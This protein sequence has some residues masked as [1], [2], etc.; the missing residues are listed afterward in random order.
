MANSVLPH[1]L[2]TAAQEGDETAKA[3]VYAELRPFLARVASEFADTPDAREELGQ[4]AALSLFTHL[5]GYVVGS[6][7]A[8]K[9][10]LLPRVRQDVRNAHFESRFLGTIDGEAASRYSRAYGEAHG[11][12]REARNRGEYVSDAEIHEDVKTRLQNIGHGLDWDDD[13]VRAADD[14]FNGGGV[15]YLSS[16]TD[17]GSDDSY[18]YDGLESLPDP[19]MDAAFLLS[20]GVVGKE[21]E[22]AVRAMKREMAT[23][24]MSHL[25]ENHR[26]TIAVS[27]GVDQA[28]GQFIAG[29]LDVRGMTVREGQ[30]EE[31]MGFGQTQVT[32]QTIALDL[33]VQRA[34]VRQWRKRAL[35][36]MQKW[37]AEWLYPSSHTSIVADEKEIVDAVRANDEGTYVTIERGRRGLVA[38][39]SILNEEGDRAL[40]W[41]RVSRAVEL[42]V[43]APEAAQEVRPVVSLFRAPV[44]AGDTYGRLYGWAQGLDLANV[45]DL[46]A[47]DMTGAVVD[48]VDRELTVR[49]V[50]PIVLDPGTDYSAPS[51]TVA[52]L[53]RSAFLTRRAY[54][55]RH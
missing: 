45:A 13:R 49:Q 12:A 43:L 1:A 2:I 21:R 30:P 36:A 8:L 26:H 4:V 19:S 28:P 7:A 27:F 6:K 42:G 46:G 31:R 34:T 29:L 18:A 17:H 44:A 39:F 20:E 41:M 35:T 24:L 50:E 55:R 33:G 25:T 51:W 52:P 15:H 38:E 16:S 22:H 23:E 3:S 5:G 47:T 14:L 54:V 37:S 10:Y 9:T 40:R 11:A 32:D 48:Q 53:E